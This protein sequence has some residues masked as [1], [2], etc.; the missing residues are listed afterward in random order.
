MNIKVKKRSGEVFAAFTDE[1]GYNGKILCYSLQDDTHFDADK[2]YINRSVK[3]RDQETINDMLRALKSRGYRN[4]V[5][6]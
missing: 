1:I 2:D 4:V 6:I 5:I 3:V